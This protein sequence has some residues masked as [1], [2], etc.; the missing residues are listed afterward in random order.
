[1]Q[2][3][4]AW[5]NPIMQGWMNYYGRYYRSALYPVFA[6][7]DFH[8]MKWAKLKLKRLGRSFRRTHVWMG[9]VRHRR[10]SLFVHWRFAQAR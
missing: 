4:A 3:I 5:V 1:L 2:E 8:L 10:P 6:H 9:R 7:L